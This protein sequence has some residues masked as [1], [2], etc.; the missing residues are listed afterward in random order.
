MQLLT[1]LSKGL[2]ESRP[3]SNFKKK[4]YI[5]IQF[6]DFTACITTDKGR[7]FCWNINVKPKIKINRV[8][9]LSKLINT[10]QNLKCV[11]PLL[12]TPE[13]LFAVLKVKTL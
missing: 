2:V 12:L 13:S 10:T 3:M 8:V 6:F 4:R 9:S 7:G 11:R 1:L 5:S